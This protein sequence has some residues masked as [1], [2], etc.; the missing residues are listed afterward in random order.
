MTKDEEPRFDAWSLVIAMR[1][2]IRTS[3]NEAMDDVTATFQ[4][5]GIHHVAQQIS[6][7]LELA[8]P[9]FSTFHFMEEIGFAP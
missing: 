9:H 3:N 7:G 6:K 1:E 2:A 5:R 8:D 4:R